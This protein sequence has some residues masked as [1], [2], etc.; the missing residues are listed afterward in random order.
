[1][2]ITTQIEVEALLSRY[3]HCIDD[4]RLEE[5]PDFFSEECRYEITSAENHERGL[6]VGMM[7]ATSRGML[8]DRVSALRQAN[9]YE[10][11]RYRHSVSSVWITGVNDGVIAVQ[12][13]FQVIRIMNNGVMDLF[14]TG[15]YLDRIVGTEAGRRYA[16]KRVILD[17]KRIDTLLA[18]PI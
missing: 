12:A 8:K 15:K 10:P 6:P 18:I 4:D 7:V 17:N 1:M 14:C 3:V 9:I 2:D 5:W 16:E 11:Q 13:N